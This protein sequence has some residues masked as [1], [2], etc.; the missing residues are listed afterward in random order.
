[1]RLAAASRLAPGSSPSAA[2]SEARKVCASAGSGKRKGA[3]MVSF[4][5]RQMLLRMQLQSE[6]A[7]QQHAA[8]CNWMPGHRPPARPP[9]ACVCQVQLVHGG[10]HAL[11]AAAAKEALELEADAVDEDVGLGGKRR[12]GGCMRAR[13][14]AGRRGIGSGRSGQ[15]ARGPGGARQSSGHGPLRAL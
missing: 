13:R 3:S 4:V 9:P 15:A 8:R 10:Q 12:L 11:Q 5:M 14:Q 6:A 1:M 2:R 7:S